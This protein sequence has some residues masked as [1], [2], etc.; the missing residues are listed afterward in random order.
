MFTWMLLPLCRALHLS[1]PTDFTRLIDDI[2]LVTRNVWKQ[3]DLRFYKF[4][5]RVDSLSREQ[6]IQGKS[7]PKFY[8]DRFT[9]NQVNIDKAVV[10]TDPERVSI[11]ITDLF[12]KGQ[13]I[14]SVVGALNESCI[15]KEVEI[16]VLTVSAP[17]TGVV[18]DVTP[19]V[20]LKNEVRPLYVLIFG[21]RSNI[22][23]VFH[24]FE[25]KSYITPGRK[26]LVSKAP[27]ND[28]EVNVIKHKHKDNK[29]INSDGGAVSRYKEYGN[30]FGFKLK[31]K[32]REALL[33]FELTVKTD[34]AFPA[35]DGENI[36]FTVLKKGAADT[37]A[38]STD[39]LLFRDVRVEGNKITG[40]IAVS[41]KN[42]E[43]KFS[44][45][46]TA[47]FNNTRPLH[48]PEWVKSY[49][50]DQYT[51]DSPKDKTIYLNKL[52]TEVFTYNTTYN[53]PAIGKFY[54]Y[55]RR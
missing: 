13:D 48:M 53:R 5:T 50:T 39:E 43:K 26:L 23:R 11:M 35:F 4:G 1:H 7:N 46:V 19:S 29:A 15:K 14:N 55:L 22:N 51:A 3:T 33:D 36:R 52:F 49:D 41:N 8:A 24:A 40:Q 28:Y 44:Y 9:A 20:S 16:G 6:F 32:D 12:Y 54:L 34:E 30:V 42:P 37:T 25:S 17:F 10:N 45:E 38:V 27:L 18:A 47:G 31:E 2:E 21:N